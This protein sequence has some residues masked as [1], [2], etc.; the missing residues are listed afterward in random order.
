[1]SLSRVVSRTGDT[2]LVEQKGE[3]G[4]LF[5]RQPVELWL[6]VVETP[7]KTIVARTVGGSFRE[8][9]GRYD[10]EEMRGRVRISYAGHFVPGF[11]LPPFLGIVAIRHTAA[12]QLTAMVEEIM[13]RDARARAASR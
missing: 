3:F 2:L 5:F 12:T 6:E 4:V 8:M 10:I 1:M 11:A 9:T 7:R 13:R